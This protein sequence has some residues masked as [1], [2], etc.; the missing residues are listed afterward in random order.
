MPGADTLQVNITAKAYGTR[1]VLSTVAFSAS[2]G[3]VLALLAPSGTG[4]TTTLRIVL[5]LDTKFSGT[6][7][8]PIGRIG[9]VFQEPRLLPW[10]S[11]GQNLSLV[12]PSL[13]EPD[14]AELLRR[15]GLEPIADLMPSSLSLGMARR[16]ALARAMAVKPS[17]L[18]MDEPFASPA[19][20]GKPARRC[21]WRHTI[22]TRRLRLR[23][24]SCCL[25]A[26][27]RQSWRPMSRAQVLTL[28]R[29]ENGSS[30]CSTNG[31]PGRHAL[32]GVQGAKPLGLADVKVKGARHV[33][34]TGMNADL[35]QPI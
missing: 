34:Q 1:Q 12:Q 7:H 22:W 20:R 4:K 21:S 3:E 13:T 9:A 26:R 30:S 15:A 25:V 32:V 23:T 17:L 14:I 29:C 5:G 28:Q 11:V 24:A 6:V 18:V 10:L 19:T 8:R 35:R 33:I 16:V 2:P 31:G 27:T